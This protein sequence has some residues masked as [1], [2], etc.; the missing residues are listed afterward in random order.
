MRR[1]PING[2]SR[3]QVEETAQ[4]NTGG[5]ASSAPAADAVH[6]RVYLGVLRAVR[7]IRARTALRPI[8]ARQGN[9]VC[10]L[11]QRDR[12]GRDWRV[13]LV[14]TREPRGRIRQRLAILRFRRRSA[15]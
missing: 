11:W 14:I 3:I 6:P 1:A 7:D 8:G 4:N 2:C 15:R 13:D 12:K 10:G 9:M 5:P